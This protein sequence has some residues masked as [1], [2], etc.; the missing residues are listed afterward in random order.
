MKNA[1]GLLLLFMTA[2]E[3]N[4]AHAQVYYM[5]AYPGG[6][7]HRVYKKRPQQKQDPG[8]PKFEP[9]VN[10]SFGYGFPN[11][12][13]YQ[14]PI[15]YNYYMGPYSQTGPV[16]G[17]VDYQFNRVVSV[18]VMV[19]HGRVSVPYYEYNNVF[20]SLRGSLSNWSFMLNLV[21]Y[22]PVASP[23]ITPYFR[24]SIG[25]NSWQQNFTDAGGSKVNMSLYPSDF[26]YQVSMG[27]KFNLTKNAGMFL[28]AG[29]G[30]YI[31][32]GGLA[33]KF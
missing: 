18:G 32:Q 3:F 14:L 17:A 30:K 5:R 24:S 7:Y 11:L 13:K 6:G 29:Y 23:K 1:V 10:V 20:P 4:P 33:F 27:A 9:T 8:L 2:A 19:T 28:E 26:A 15:F 22:M 16:T 12:D 21:R 31:L 25:V